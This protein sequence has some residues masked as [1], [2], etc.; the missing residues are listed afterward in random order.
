[1]ERSEF[2]STLCG[3]QQREALGI[4]SFVAQKPNVFNDSTVPA[5]RANTL[6]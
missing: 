2:H 6:S 1:M 4:A 5:A 3:L